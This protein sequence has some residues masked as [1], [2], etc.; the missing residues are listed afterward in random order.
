MHIYSK[1][2]LFTSLFKIYNISLAMH[3][4]NFNLP[5]YIQESV[6]RIKLSER[7]KILFEF[8][9]SDL[10]NLDHRRTRFPEQQLLKFVNLPNP[11]YPTGLQLGCA[12]LT[13]YVTY[14]NIGCM[15]WHFAGILAVIADI[16]NMYNVEC[17]PLL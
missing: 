1:D 11:V 8:C 13:S 9:K 3:T 16:S 15:S 5:K 7:R 14:H 6:I 2:I 4:Q 12:L 17:N 10:M